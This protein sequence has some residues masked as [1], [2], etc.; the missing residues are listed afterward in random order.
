MFRLHGML[1]RPRLRL[2]LEEVLR[3]YFWHSEWSSSAVG[4]AAALL[5][6]RLCHMPACKLCMKEPLAHGFQRL[7]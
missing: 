6:A 7:P 1:A 3:R 4:L 5:F 2:T